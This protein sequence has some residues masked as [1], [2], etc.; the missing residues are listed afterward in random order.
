MSLLWSEICIRVRNY[1]DNVGR[2]FHRGR[3]LLLASTGLFYCNN[4]SVPSCKSSRR[5]ISF[6]HFPAKSL[7]SK[8]HLNRFLIFESVDPFIYC[9]LKNS[10][11]HYA[12]LKLSFYIIIALIIRSIVKFI[13]SPQITEMWVGVI[14]HA[15]ATAQRDVAFPNVVTSLDVKISCWPMERGVMWSSDPYKAIRGLDVRCVFSVFIL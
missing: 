11:Q 9:P 6:P 2:W 15:T 4:N 10:A 13:A 7:L 12:W 5:K 14:C 1:R 3:K 8:I